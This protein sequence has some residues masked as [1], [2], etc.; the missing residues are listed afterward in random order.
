MNIFKI[1]LTLVGAMMLGACI[2]SSTGGLTDLRSDEVLTIEIELE[3][4]KWNPQP[5]LEILADGNQIGYYTRS[6][7]PGKIVDTATVLDAGK[8]LLFTI[9]SRIEDDDRMVTISDKDNREARISAP[10]SPSAPVMADVDLFDW[11][12]SLRSGYARKA[13]TEGSRHRQWIFSNADGA[14]EMVIETKVWVDDFRAAVMVNSSL[15]SRR[16]ELLLFSVLSV[17]F[18]ELDAVDRA[19]E[20]QERA[21][22]QV[23]DEARKDSGFSFGT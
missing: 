22:G 19:R 16:D 7:K 10:Y 17:V 1:A 11:P 23:M 4:P 12:Y 8:N 14:A 20:A 15:M 18:E 21:A 9:Y 3:K 13:G 6:S 5:E 2:S